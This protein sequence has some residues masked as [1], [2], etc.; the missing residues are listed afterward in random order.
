PTSATSGA[1]GPVSPV[2]GE[3][4]GVVDQAATGG[5]VAESRAPGQPA[6]GPSPSAA[7]SGTDREG[8]EPSRGARSRAARQRQ[9]LSR[10]PAAHGYLLFTRRRIPLPIKRKKVA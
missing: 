4:A 7:A 8:A 2:A 9:A 1:P 10:A 6:A 3:A 5:A